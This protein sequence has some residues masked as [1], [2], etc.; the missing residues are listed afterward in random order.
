MKRKETTKTFMTISNWNKP[1]GLDGLYKNISAIEGF[2]SQQRVF[3]DIVQEWAA[4]Q[5]KYVEPV[6][7]QH[8]TGTSSRT[9]AGMSIVLCSGKTLTIE[10]VTK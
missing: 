9:G 6:L 3:Q 2:F 1:I 5:K 7:A 8:W 10:P 4:K